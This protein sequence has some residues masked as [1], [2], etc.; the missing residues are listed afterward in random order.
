MIE[1]VYTFS[2]SPNYCLDNW[3]YFKNWKEFVLFG[4]KELILFTKPFREVEAAKEGLSGLLESTEITEIVDA[5]LRGQNNEFSRIYDAYHQQVVAVVRTIVP[6]DAIE[7]VTHEAFVRAFKGLSKYQEQGKFLA[8]LRRI[9]VRASHD[10]WRAYRNPKEKPAAPEMITSLLD[11][12]EALESTETSDLRSLLLTSLT[13]LEVEDR[14]V[15]ILRY[16]EEWTVVEVATALNWSVS[17]TKIRSLRA[18]RKLHTM[19]SNANKSEA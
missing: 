4:T 3:T 10:Y 16:L 9:S 19:I 8:W 5:V 11:D 6:S 1:R 18:R 17:K 7:E 15:V 14:T 2:A 12:R 13:R